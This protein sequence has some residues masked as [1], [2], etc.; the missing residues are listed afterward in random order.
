VE[1][2]GRAREARRWPTRGPERAAE[3]CEAGDTATADGQDC[4]RRAA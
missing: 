2:D 3:R 1:H 4:E